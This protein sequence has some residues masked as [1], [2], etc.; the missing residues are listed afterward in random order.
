MPA[1]RPTHVSASLV[2]CAVGPCLHRACASD[3]F[4]PWHWP[5]LSPRVLRG[6]RMLGRISRLCCPCASLSRGVA[7]PQL[8]PSATPAL[9]VSPCALS[10]TCNLSVYG[11]L[12][13]LSLLLELCTSFGFRLSRTSG[14]PPLCTQLAGSLGAPV[15]VVAIAIVEAVLFLLHTAQVGVSPSVP[16]ALVPDLQLLVGN[17]ELLLELFLVSIVPEE[18]TVGPLAYHLEDLKDQY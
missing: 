4:L 8:P 16:L 1:L 5:P 6:M 2:S 7:P 15:V 14:P 13:S 3:R 9:T 10:P 18:P 11:D 12:E 17:Q